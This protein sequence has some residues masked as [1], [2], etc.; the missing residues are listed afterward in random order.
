MIT[1]GDIGIAQAGAP[2]SKATGPE[3]SAGKNPDN[4]AK[5][6]NKKEF[7][8]H[9]K[10]EQA[11][12]DEACE[13]AAA[14]AA[15]APEKTESDT[16]TAL[17]VPPTTVNA[18]ITAENLLQLQGKPLPTEGNSLPLAAANESADA[19]ADTSKATISDPLLK[20]PQTPDTAIVAGE[21]DPQLAAAQSGLVAPSLAANPKTGGAD[22]NRTTTVAGITATPEGSKLAASISAQA[23]PTADQSRAGS[24]EASSLIPPQTAGKAAADLAVFGDPLAAKSPVVTES[25]L[26]AQ[27][28]QLLKPVNPEALAAVEKLADAPLNI[29][30]ASNENSYLPGLGS[31][32]SDLTAVAAKTEVFQTYVP[33]EVGK[34]GWSESIM[35]K[36]M[37]MSSSQ[38]SKAEIALDPPE[39]GP[40]QIRISTQSDQTS[41]SFTSASPAV[42]ESLD[43][44]LARLRELFDSQGLDLANVDVSDQGN[45]QANAGEADSSSEESGESGMGQASGQMAQDDANESAQLLT[46]QRSVGMGLIDQFV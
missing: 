12:C 14:V 17:V 46:S 22:S 21:T 13:T 24:A 41:V 2:G 10:D 11:H 26:A 15:K 32:K 34:A 43:Q 6:L 5:P 42:R 37:W 36:V 1:T 20:A 30:R 38:L 29:N 4:T 19:Q 16:E 45:Q 40:L 39:L 31:L 8:D 33:Q 7:S 27:G 25:P 18:D 23:V 9:L 35:Q 3:N 44:G 28:A